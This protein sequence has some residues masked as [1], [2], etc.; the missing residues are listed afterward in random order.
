VLHRDLYAFLKDT[1]QI[2]DLFTGRIFHEWVPQENDK[3][4]SLVFSLTSQIEVAED[5]EQP[6]D[7]K[8]DQSNYQFDVYGRKSADTIEAADTFDSVFRNFTGTMGAT[9]IQRIELTSNTHL[10]EIV[11]DKTVR[12]VSLDYAIFHDA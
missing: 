9:R 8:I 6:G 7:E 1:A 2:A 5:M 11:G 4:P 12:R 3:W 10:G